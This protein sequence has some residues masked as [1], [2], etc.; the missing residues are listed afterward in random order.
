MFLCSKSGLQLGFD[1]VS[2]ATIDT[3]VA[4]VAIHFQ[5]VM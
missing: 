1:C 4:I 3:D 5:S 2:I